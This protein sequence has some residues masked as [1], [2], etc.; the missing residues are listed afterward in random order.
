MHSQPEF[1]ALLAILDESRPYNHGVFSFDWNALTDIAIHHGVGPL[2]AMRCEE[3]SLTM[4]KATRQ[5]IAAMELLTQMRNQQRLD[6][7]VE[8]SAAAPCLIWILS[9]RAGNMT[10]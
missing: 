10:L 2:L 8:L 6:L 3:I 1:N 5:T 4:P 7:L 9:H